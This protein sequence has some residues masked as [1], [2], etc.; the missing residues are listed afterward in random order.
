LDFDLL[1][2]IKVR[3]FENK[4][5]LVDLKTE[6]LIFMILIWKCCMRRIP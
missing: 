5:S 3:N 4:N 2:S 6:D 1:V